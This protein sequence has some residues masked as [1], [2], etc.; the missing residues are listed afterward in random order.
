MTTE[1]MKKFYALCNANAKT[2]MEAGVVVSNIPLMSMF[3]SL[4]DIMEEM[5]HQS[6][7]YQ[8]GLVKTV[9]KLTKDV[10]Q[11]EIPPK[12]DNRESLDGASTSA[13][14]LGVV[15]R[16]ALQKN[17]LEDLVNLGCERLDEIQGIRRVGDI[18]DDDTKYYV[19][20]KSRLARMPDYWDNAAVLELSLIMRTKNLTLDIKG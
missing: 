2:A 16:S 18:Y 10:S 7:E 3:A 1:A 11:E 14:L 5:A 6:S 4:I 13:T 15:P 19:M 9:A 20:V 12:K 8:E 17:I